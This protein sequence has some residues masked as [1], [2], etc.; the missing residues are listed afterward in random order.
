MKEIYSKVEPEKL[1]HIIY[2][3]Q[4]FYD[5]E[6][7][8]AD[9][10]PLNNFLQLATLRLEKDQTFKPHK[11]IWKEGEETVIAQE[12]WVCIKGEVQVT[13][14]DLDNSVVHEPILQPGDCSIT[15]L[16]GHTYQA[17]KEDTI[18]YEYKTGPY[19]GQKLDKEFIND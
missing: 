12:S 1:L 8:R 4:D 14:Y 18:V 10:I 7:F 19:K 2:R 9:V 5:Q 16:G 3:L 13:L 15:L 11:H 6:S 17:L